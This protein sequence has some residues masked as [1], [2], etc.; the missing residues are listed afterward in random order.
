MKVIKI[1]FLFGFLLGLAACSS[2]DDDDF[3]TP[4]REKPETVTEKLTQ[5]LTVPTNP[6]GAS[7]TLIMGTDLKIVNEP[8][9]GHGS[10][11]YQS[12][13]PVVCSV[14]ANGTITLLK[15]GICTIEARF[16]GNDRYEPSPWVG[17][18]TFS[19]S[20]K[21]QTLIVPANPYGKSP[22]LVLGTKLSIV[23][24][25]SGGQG[26]VEYRSET[27]LV[28][29][30]ASNGAI[31]L[32]KAGTCSIEARFA[33]NTN[34]APSPWADLITLL[35]TKK[36][37][38]LTP[39]T[40]PYGAKPLPV[41]GGNNLSLVNKPT[42]GFGALT[43]RFS[44]LLST[45]GSCLVNTSTGEITPKTAGV[46][47]VEARFAGDSEYA[48]SPWTI[49]AAINVAK[50]TG[51]TPQTL[52]PSVNPYGGSPSLVVGGSAL[53]ISNAPSGGHG[54]VEYQTTTGAICQ[55]RLAD[56]TVN[57]LTVGA[58]AIHARFAGDSTYQS[59]DWVHLI[60]INVGKGS[61]TPTTYS[62]PYGTSPSL[63]VGGSRLP[64]QRPPVGKG[65]LRYQVTT[66]HCRVNAGTGEIT[67]VSVGPCVV[68]AK[69]SGDRNYNASARVQVVRIE[70]AAKNAVSTQFRFTGNPVYLSTTGHSDWLQVSCPVSYYTKP[71][72]DFLIL[73]DNL[74]DTHYTD[75]TTAKNALLSLAHLAA[76]E[77]DLRFV[78]AP[79]FVKSGE[80]DHWKLK[81]VANTPLVGSS[82]PAA[83]VIIPI[84]KLPETLESFDSEITIRTGEEKGVLRA[85]K[86]VKYGLTNKIFRPESYLNVVI[87]SSGDDDQSDADLKTSVHNLLCSR[88]H[89][90][91]AVV[92]SGS[93]D[94]QVRPKETCNPALSSNPKEYPQML[95]FHSVTYPDNQSIS[96]YKKASRWIY[97][98]AYEDVHGDNLDGA[99]NR[100]FPNDQS[101]RSA[102]D[103]H[104]VRG[105]GGSGVTFL[106]ALDNIYYS[107]YS[108][109]TR[110]PYKYWPI[111]SEHSTGF[112]AQDIE[113]IYLEDGNSEREIS[114]SAENGYSFFAGEF[115]DGYLRGPPN[116]NQK[117][118]GEV[119]EF[120]GQTKIYY[121][122][123]LKAELSTGKEECFNGIALPSTPDIATLTLKIN[124]EAL[125]R[126]SGVDTNWKLLK[127]NNESIEFQTSYNILADC[128][129]GSDNNNAINRTGYILKLLNGNMYKNTDTVEVDYD[130]TY[131]SSN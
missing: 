40:N 15:E 119:V 59:S 11:E 34:Y 6:Y 98:Q 41:A 111:V 1:I 31:T 117:F 84:E 107:V 68:Q 126:V 112:V 29:G 89:Y 25:P 58:C 52:T 75:S 14:A 120:H 60:T 90:S 53:Q 121:P 73:W 35:G 50:D 27:S 108:N 9:G 115:A 131:P 113:R 99:L 5:K 125:D 123:C 12:D 17:L 20:K 130:V 127:D 78:I 3:N 85:E 96:K 4:P 100:F 118:S 28:C 101:G 129:D 46:C 80:S 109:I 19:G 30:V 54:G 42:G 48:A 104:N 38:S 110:H 122:Q 74:K 26:S 43:Y 55:V 128:S 86:L 8:S 88:G 105:S 79:L 93:N 44:S 36:A 21:T 61:Q 10:V 97:Y 57:A 2:D 51:K 24:E 70:V 106:K 39:K 18:I 33:G 95:R 87:I 114:I 23:N 77:F 16:T 62:N 82:L 45:A 69:F 71:K 37:Q 49:I 64:I 92:D 72:V 102:P 56:G 7:P 76:D 94:Q 65:T 22:T 63:S 13:T 83:D 32:L 103:Y 116:Y 66:T 124:G 81:F 91:E 47:V 67:P